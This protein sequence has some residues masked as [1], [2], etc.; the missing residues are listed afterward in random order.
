MKITLGIFLIDSYKG[1][2]NRFYLQS[3]DSKTLR[4][5]LTQNGSLGKNTVHRKKAS[6]TCLLGKLQTLQET[7]WS[8]LR[9]VFRIMLHRFQLRCLT[10]KIVFWDA[11]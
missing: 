1:K 3:V 4:H 9:N 8:V 7:E 6:N 10:M 5:G 2:L 11:H